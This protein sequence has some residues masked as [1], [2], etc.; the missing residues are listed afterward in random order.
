MTGPAGK[1]VH[2]STCPVASPGVVMKCLLDAGAD[3]EVGKYYGQK[4]IHVA[5]IGGYVTSINMLC[6]HGADVDAMVEDGGTA[7]H[8]AAFLSKPHAVKALV[9]NGADLNA[10]MDNGDTPPHVVARMT[11][12]SCDKAGLV[13][14]RDTMDELLLLGADETLLN[15]DG[16]A[17]R[18]VVGC[19]DKREYGNGDINAPEWRMVIGMFYRTLK[20]APAD[21]AWR[22][23]GLLVL[24]RV[25]NCL[26]A[27]AAS[28]S[29]SPRSGWVG[30]AGWTLSQSGAPFEIF[31]NIVS[32][33]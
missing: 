8:E 9:E 32:F 29:V 19:W 11:G 18:H 20:A 1:M 12:F 4:P 24:V 22:R 5:A 3:M 16:K 21:R 14:T 33:L 31:R 23:R 7:L 10:R 13:A 17:P 28:E 25:K 15:N 2:L 6:D 27:D 26:D 30:V